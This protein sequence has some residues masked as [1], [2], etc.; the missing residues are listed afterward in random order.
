MPRT[1]RA[2][3]LGEFLHDGR[4]AEPHTDTV[5]LTWAGLEA[6]RASLRGWVVLNAEEVVDTCERIHIGLTRL[7]DEEDGEARP[8]VLAAI[9][10]RL[11][12]LRAKALLAD[13]LAGRLIFV[14]LAREAAAGFGPNVRVRVEADGRAYEVG[15]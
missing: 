2:Q 8:D 10:A 1:S 3:R 11:D 4:P 15:P 9:R 13:E 14:Y 6:E 7:R 12:E 5:R